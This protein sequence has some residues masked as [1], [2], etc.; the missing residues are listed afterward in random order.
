MRIGLLSD[1]H[2]EFYDG[3]AWRDFVACIDVDALDVLI[4][5]GDICGASQLTRVLSAFCFK[6]VEVVYVTGNH[7]YYRS[8]FDAVHEVLARLDLA[9][10]HWLHNSAVEING[11]RFVGTTMWFPH[12]P[13]QTMGTED[14][15]DFRLIEGFAERVGEE[16]R[17]AQRFLEEAVRPG[18]VV[19][20]HHLP[21][22][23]CVP[24]RFAS[25]PLNR[26]FVC[27]Q[28]ELVLQRRPALWVHGH[29][30]ASVD[31]ELGSTR[32]VCNPFGYLG[33]ELNENFDLRL[34]MEVGDE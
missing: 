15:S 23:R 33:F 30:H 21:S 7:E 9:N 31:V 3:D 29:S 10:L 19:V 14:L 17:A 4:L 28:D 12:H 27:P 18:D 16:N 34:T 13:A 25:S 8:D 22:Q 6:E 5:A 2:F 32:V 26:F 11:Q 20:T 24:M 1:L